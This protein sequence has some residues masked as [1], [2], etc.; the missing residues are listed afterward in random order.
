MRDKEITRENKRTFYDVIIN[1]SENILFVLVFIMV[2]VVFAN[3][4]ARYI[5]NSAITESEELARYCFVWSVFIGAVLALEKQQHIGIDLVIKNL[6][7]SIQKW[8]LV[9]SNMCILILAGL[10][11]Y[12]GFILCLSSM[13]WPS[14]ALRIPHGIVG[15]IVP[16]SFLAVLVITI[17]NIIKLIRSKI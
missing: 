14:P 7:V 9:F 6:P 4:V 1:I 5:F 12:Y 17:N 16:I 11:S 13:G 2:M 8:V 10:C 15:M 3:V